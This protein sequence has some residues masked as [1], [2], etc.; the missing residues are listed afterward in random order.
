VDKILPGL[1]IAVCVVLL[2]RLLMGETR[3]WR[4]D[5]LMRRWFFAAQRRVLLLWNWRSSRKQAAKV[6]E[7]AIR[8]ARASGEWDG[9]VYRPDVFHKKPPKDKLH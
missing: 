6:A 8:R 2:A 7:E 5:A 1:T 3:R 4:F 9:K